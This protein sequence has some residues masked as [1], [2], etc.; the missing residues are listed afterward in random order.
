M[1][2]AGSE[3]PNSDFANFETPVYRVKFMKFDLSKN[4]LSVGIIY[5]KKSFFYEQILCIYKTLFKKKNHF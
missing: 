2:K 4:L 1:N 5:L 3:R